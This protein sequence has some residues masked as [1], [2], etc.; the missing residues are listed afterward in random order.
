MQCANWVPQE[1]ETH[2]PHSFG[3]ATNIDILPTAT[4]KMKQ[5][6]R[7]VEGWEAVLFH[8]GA[9]AM[10]PACSLHSAT[11]VTA[12]GCAVLENK[13]GNPSGSPCW[14]NT[15]RKPVGWLSTYICL[16]PSHPEMGAESKRERTY[17]QSDSIGGVEDDHSLATDKWRLAPRLSSAPTTALQ[18]PPS[19]GEHTWDR[20]SDFFPM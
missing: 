15:A 10:A 20:S 12:G 19:Q 9:G 11:T 5:E 17:L 18:T 16:S 2:Q 4:R 13:P 7:E 8:Q 6:N 14:K 1:S 3:K